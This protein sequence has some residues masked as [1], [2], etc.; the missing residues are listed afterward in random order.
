MQQLS[1]PLVQTQSFVAGISTCYSS[2]TQPLS[3][4]EVCVA[5]KVNLNIIGITMLESST[6]A[7]SS[8]VSVFFLFTPHGLKSIDTLSYSLTYPTYY[9]RLLCTASYA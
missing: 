6:L 2:T 3:R 4:I 8:Y 7:S 1:D 5:H 9:Q